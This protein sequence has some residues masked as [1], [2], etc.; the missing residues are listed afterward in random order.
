MP[1]F[2]EA[3]N[4]ALVDFTLLTSEDRYVYTAT[5]HRRGAHETSQA[6]IISVLLRQIAGL[7]YRASLRTLSV[8]A[9][10]QALSFS[11]SS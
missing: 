6:F 9:A 11:R 5:F 2:N 3:G 8:C 10:R 7:T 1:R 4:K